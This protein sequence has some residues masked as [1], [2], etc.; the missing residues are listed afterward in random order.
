MV[1]KGTWGAHVQEATVGLPS[2]G[3]ATPL[4]AWGVGYLCSCLFLLVGGPQLSV[5]PSQRGP[6]SVLVFKAV[7]PSSFLL[8]PSS[9]LLPPSSFLLPPSSFLLPPSSFL[10]PPSSFLMSQPPRPPPSSPACSAAAPPPACPAAGPPPPAS[11]AG[12]RGPAASSCGRGL[13]APR[14]RAAR[15]RCARGAGTR[16]ARRK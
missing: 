5:V 11:S 8:P 3:G 9:F 10:L 4:L 13:S 16:A 6:F 14:P 1:L 2:G 7:P 15:G 12:P